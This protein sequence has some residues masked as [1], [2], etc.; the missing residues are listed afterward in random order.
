MPAKFRTFISITTLVFLVIGLHYLGYLNWLENF[1]RSLVS[2]VSQKIYS[3]EVA[4]NGQTENFNSVEDLKKAYQSS[5]AELLTER[6]E[7]V[8]QQL[9]EEENAELKT[10]LK[11]VQ[12]KKVTSVGAEVIGKN[13]DPVG[14]TLV[15]NRGR[16]SGIAPEDPVIV[17]EGIVVGKIARVEANLSVVRLLNDN[18]SKVAATIMNQDKS[19][20]IIEGG[21]GISVQ[22][23]YIPQN[24]T[25]NVGDV[26]VTSGLEGNILRGL[27]VGTIEAVEKEAYQ[28][29]QKAMVKPFVN[30]DKIRLVSVILNNAP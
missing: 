27:M 14:N 29:F 18:Q 24:E 26:V 4:I 6:S 23:N 19:L 25:V 1:L 20:G 12:A 15:I 16:E 5:M 21:Y 2:P 9:L 7:N 10:Q 8:K 11:F 3:L 13:I 22:M 30:L 17:G 28:P